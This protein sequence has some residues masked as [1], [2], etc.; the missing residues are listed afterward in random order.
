MKL[1][2]LRDGRLIALA[3][4]RQ[5]MEQDRLIL[6]L[7]KLEGPGEERD[8]MPV[9]RPVIAEPEFFENDARDEKVFDPFLDFVR[10]MKC[11][12]ASDRLDEAPAFSCKCA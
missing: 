3:L 5:D 7:E 6:L 1:V 12:L 4:F 11:A 9:D 2:R 10:Q 8:I